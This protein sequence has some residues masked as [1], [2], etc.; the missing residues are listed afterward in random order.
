[1]QQGNIVMPQLKQ[2]GGNALSGSE[3]V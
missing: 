2:H 1:M 3:L